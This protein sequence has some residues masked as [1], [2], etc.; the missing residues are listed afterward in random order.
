MLKGEHGMESVKNPMVDDG[1]TYRAPH[2]SF[3]TAIRGQKG[4]YLRFFATG[5]NLS[6]FLYAKVLQSIT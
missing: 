4:H 1:L 5:K 2:L 3:C 6:A